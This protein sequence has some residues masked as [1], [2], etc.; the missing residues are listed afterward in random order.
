ME[1]ETKEAKTE[2]GDIKERAAALQISNEF[3]WEL[4]SLNNR[5]DAICAH[6]H[7]FQPSAPAATE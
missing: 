5:F 4:D 2:L 7:E 3:I 6:L 1:N